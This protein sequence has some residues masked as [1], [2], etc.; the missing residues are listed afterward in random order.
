MSLLPTTGRPNR[1][2]LLMRLLILRLTPRPTRTSFV[3][4]PGAKP[5]FDVNPSFDP[6]KLYN[7]EDGSVGRATTGRNA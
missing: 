6:D 7:A 5:S 4:E 1:S 3:V 2:F